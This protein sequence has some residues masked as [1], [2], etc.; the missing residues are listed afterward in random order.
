MLD[1]NLF[2]SLTLLVDQLNEGHATMGSCVEAALRALSERDAEGLD[3][4]LVELLAASRTH[5]LQ[6]EAL[7]LRVEY[8]QIIDHSGRHEQL[9]HGL[10]KMQR[11]QFTSVK[12]PAF[13]QAFSGY[14]TSWYGAHIQR[15]DT[16]FAHFL[17]ER[18]RGRLNFDDSGIAH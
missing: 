1:G 9:L 2:T 11:I 16:A 18:D 7:M 8:P 3:R 6:E 13:L 4:S 15:D 10:T 5:F 14:L 17:L 12:T